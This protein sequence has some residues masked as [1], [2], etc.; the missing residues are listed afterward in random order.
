MGCINPKTG[1][2]RLRYHGEES[3]NRSIILK[4]TGGNISH[5][6]VANKFPREIEQIII[7][8]LKLRCLNDIPLSNTILLLIN[9]VENTVEK[10]VD[11]RNKISE[12]TA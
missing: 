1:I 7:N 9:T 4:I 2:V 8:K 6:T 12:L 3:V 5:A 10:Y 11:L